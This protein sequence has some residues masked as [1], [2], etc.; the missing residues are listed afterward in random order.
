M[1][2]TA[3]PAAAAQNAAQNTPAPA[4]PAASP[5]PASSVLVVIDRGYWPKTRPADLPADE[6][7]R[8]REGETVLLP[9]EEAMDVVEAGI[10]RRVRRDDAAN[11]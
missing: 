6:E 7:Y 9:V 2:D 4:A 1:A 5:A 11:S 8:V 3:K 10:G